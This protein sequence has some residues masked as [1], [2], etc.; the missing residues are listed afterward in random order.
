MKKL[1]ILPLL[2]FFLPLHAARVQ[3]LQTID[4]QK[5]RYVIEAAA[6][7]PVSCDCTEITNP[8]GSKSLIINRFKHIHKV[9]NE[10][11]CV[12][13]NPTD[14]FSAISGTTKSLLMAAWMGGGMSWTTWDNGTTWWRI[15]PGNKYIEAPDPWCLQ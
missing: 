15:V 2:L 9:G 1:F 7:I 4:L 5:W 6:M 8:D 10:I 13:V 11:S 14:F 3:P 12:V